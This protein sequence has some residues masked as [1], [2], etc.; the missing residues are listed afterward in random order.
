MDL[1]TPVVPPDR[2]HPNF[3]RI[4][5][6][7]Y[8]NSRTILKEWAQGFVDR[9]GKFILEFQTT[10][11]SAF[12]EL[13]IYAVLKQ[14][15]RRVDFRFDA[16]DF[17]VNSVPSFSVEAVT[18]QAAAGAA[19]EWETPLENFW[20]DLYSLSRAPL[21]DQATVRLANAISS[22]YRQYQKRYATLAHVQGKPFVLA[23]APFEQPFSYMQLNQAILRVLLGYDYSVRDPAGE[24]IKDRFMGSI[25]KPNGSN[26][27]LGYFMRPGMEGISA[28]IFSST[29]TFGK[30]RAL[31]KENDSQ[32]VLIKAL[33][34]DA[35]TRSICQEVC[36]LSQYNETLHDG[37]NVYYNPF[38]SQPLDRTVFDAPGVS[39][40]TVNLD[41]ETIRCDVPDRALM[42]RI[43]VTIH[44]T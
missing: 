26:I 42:M 6:P 2:F 43:T 14:M 37:L 20:G 35:K 39:H 3:A 5:H 19:N 29:A 23:V 10:F 8:N 16:P 31:S 33:R 7:A 30:V 27:V 4:L 9:D 41:R 28:V 34:F 24:K 1:F 17:V 44:A 40:F 25:R 12:W 38:A 21:V 13:Y 15:G 18:A 11:N 36:E 32:K 22:K